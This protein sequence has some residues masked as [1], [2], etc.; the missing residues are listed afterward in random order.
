MT[1][2]DTMRRIAF[3]TL[4]ILV[5]GWTVVVWATESDVLVIIQKYEKAFNNDDLGGMSILISDDAMI[6][7]KIAKRKVTKPEWAKIVADSIKARSIV[8][9]EFKDLKVTTTEPTRALVTGNINVRTTNAR[10][11]WLHEWKLE[12]RNGQWLI[13]ETNFRN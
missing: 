7:S 4:L 12:Q 6:D 5:L 10:P 11:S 13:V 2:E 1:T 9:A 8:S 3:S